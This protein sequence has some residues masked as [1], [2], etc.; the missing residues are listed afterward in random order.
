[1]SEYT[2]G[3]EPVF[4]GLNEF[5]GMARGVLGNVSPAQRRVRAAEAAREALERALTLDLKHL[6][7]DKLVLEIMELRGVLAG[8]LTASIPAATPYPLGTDLE[9]NDDDY[10][11]HLFDMLGDVAPLGAE[12]TVHVDRPLAPALVDTLVHGINAPEARPVGNY[13][14]ADGI[15]GTSR[16]HLTALAGGT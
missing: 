5:S 6:T 4:P 12:V 1:M 7:P 16:V 11:A 3:P 9:L 14:Q 10:V 15:C 8:L 13:F 2:T